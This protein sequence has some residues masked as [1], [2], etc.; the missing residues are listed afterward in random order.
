[1]PQR[2][3]VFA[4]KRS[5]FW[6]WPDAVRHCVLIGIW[7]CL[8]CGALSA[9]GTQPCS[10]NPSF[11]AKG[12]FTVRKIEI[13][14]PLDFLFTVRHSLAAYKPELPLQA[15]GVFSLEQ[16]NAAHELL[17]Q[18]MKAVESSG[19]QRFRLLVVTG[20]IEHC[21][22]GPAGQLDVVFRIF[23]T[24]YNS[25][26]SHSLE[27]KTEEIA[28]PA[29]AAG[30]QQAKGA[31]LF[32]PM[33]GYNRT[34]RGFGGGKMLL[35]TPGGF[36]DAVQLTAT[37]STAGNTQELEL[38]GSRNP[39]ISGL[40]HLEYRLGYYHADTP[41]GSN[42]I[43]E[44]RLY[45]QLFGATQPLGEQKVVVR[46]GA[47]LA[48]GNQQTNM[49]AALAGSNDVANSGYGSLKTFVGATARGKRYSFA[50]SYGL[51]L[52]TNGAAASVDFVKHVADA[53]LA[54]RFL[55]KEDEPNNG[56]FHKPLDLEL[57]FSGGKI[58]T[59]GKLPVAERFFGGN[60]AEDFIAGDNWRIRGGPL[61][62]S[63][64]ENRLNAA[65]TR[66]PFGG[67]S[68]YAVNLTV[69]RPVW[70]YPIIPRELAQEKEFFENLNASKENTRKFLTAA[71]KKDV[72]AFKAF[73][74]DAL[75]LEQDVKLLSA[76]L[77]T[78][79]AT[80]TLTADLRD[81]FQDARDDVMDDV[82]SLGETFAKQSELPGKLD[83]LVKEADSNTCKT[84]EDCSSITRLRRH[85]TALAERLGQT[86]AT[87]AVEHVRQIQTSLQSHQAALVTKLSGPQFAEAEQA[88]QTLADEDL[89][90]V[91]PVLH[92]F[93]HELNLISLS[94]VFIFDAA[95]IWPDKFGTRYGI[96]GGM[97]LTLV[98]FNVTLGYAV[99]PQPHA[100]EGRGAFFFSMDVTDL[101]R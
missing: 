78:L 49:P 37:G 28:E 15:G 6:P 70:G 68:F 52:G 65:A 87:A 60:R 59:L 54:A 77:D 1:M 45:A 36:F 95:R 48:G 92:S 7:L 101:F 73:I 61:V 3:I 44:G 100:R 18:R 57:Q 20:Q 25:Y 9:A 14:S 50:G 75:L 42:R 39:Q 62:R 11:Y 76:A 24:D 16:F 13:R 4:D 10:E 81:N 12:N 69:S 58:Q 51:Q 32:K 47:A 35:R 33:A 34:R 8:G 80:D 71:R 74:A 26:L 40:D 43:R 53:A 83:G 84:D 66:G 91:E 23:T 86:N 2:I 46:F 98:N 55:P 97:R 82:F 85:L 63:I 29:T 67:T 17:R 88:A 96:G 79:P 27:A 21:D 31:F 56:D 41:A 38:V 5:A 93:L 72:P 99:N 64:P 94:P 22:A 90:A 30:T 89:K 19:D